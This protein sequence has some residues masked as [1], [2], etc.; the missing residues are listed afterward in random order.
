MGVTYEEALSGGG[1]RELLSAEEALRAAQMY[2]DMGWGVWAGP[3][4]G[5]DGKCACKLRG[6]CRNPGKHA[7][8]GWGNES[9]RTLSREQIDRWWSPLNGRWKENP[10]D[11]VFI[12]PYL[13]GLLVADVDDS[14]AWE[15]V[16]EEDRPE[17]L[18][19]RSGSG[20]GG[21][22][23]YTFS[24]D[25]SLPVPPAVRGRLLG[26]AGEVKFRGIVAAPPSVH[27]SGGRYLWENWGCPLAE[28]P[29]SMWKRGMDDDSARYDWEAIVGSRP[30]ENRWFDAMFVADKG[31]MEDAATAASIRPRVLFAVAATMAK[32]IS[33]GR[34][35]EE[36]VISELLKAAELNGALDKY[37]VSEMERQIR[38]G[39]RMGMT[40]KSVV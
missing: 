11:Q 8:P 12:V 37:G 9:R 19:S 33:A 4:I 22:Y 25:V 16:S 29:V 31:R 7:Y 15:E 21:H 39:I 27:V 20:R 13:S 5:A 34:I 2:S 35:T 36:V 23:F 6:R 3:G 10:V 17:T 30:G 38:N 1:S 32:W 18:W 28:A 14:A 26:G 40:E 24:W